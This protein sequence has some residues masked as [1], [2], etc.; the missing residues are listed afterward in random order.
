[1]PVPSALKRRRKRAVKDRPYDWQDH[2]MSREEA[3][4][5]LDAAARFRKLHGHRVKDRPAG[6]RMMDAHRHR[7]SA[8]AS[9]RRACLDVGFHLP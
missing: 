5:Q 7:I 3:F 2:T 6:I 9:N 1:M 8:V 4:Y